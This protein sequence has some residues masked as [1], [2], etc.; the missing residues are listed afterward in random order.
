MS[1]E[2]GPPVDPKSH[3]ETTTGRDNELFLI[4]KFIFRSVDPT[5]KELRGELWDAGFSD[6]S[7]LRDD[8]NL[9]LSDGGGSVRLHL[10]GS[11]DDLLAATARWFDVEGGDDE[12]E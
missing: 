9:C 6:G 3:C 7:Y 11:Y 5:D 2:G 8:L 1:I 12:G 4:E 10:G